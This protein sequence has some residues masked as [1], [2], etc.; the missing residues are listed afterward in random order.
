MSERKITRTIDAVTFLL[1]LGS[2]SL[3]LL[4]Y[5][6]IPSEVPFHY[7]TNGRVNG[8]E[9]KSALWVS[10][11]ILIAIILGLTWGEHNVLSQSS[12]GKTPPE[13]QS[14]HKPALFISVIKFTLTVTVL[15]T[16][17]LSAS[18]AEEVP[19]WLFLSLILFPLLCIGW[20]IWHLKH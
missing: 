15:T 10:E 14:N 8:M 6:S 18:L 7:D 2:V 11:A 12:S 5:D 20:G 3:L 4:F 13:I 9:P 1:I 19:S 16:Q 17:W